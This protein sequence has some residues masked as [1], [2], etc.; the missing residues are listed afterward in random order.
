MH[1]EHHMRFRRYLMSL[2]VVLVAAG[3]T[4]RTVSHRSPSAAR[5]AGAT[6]ARDAYPPAV[7]DRAPAADL[8]GLVLGQTRDADDG[9][10][11]LP[12]PPRPMVPRSVP[13]VQDS[14]Q[15]PRGR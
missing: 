2:T 9:V 15:R 4:D 7:A 8:S 1:R 14:H 12:P 11:E 3:C 6:A 10:R 5:G 13:A